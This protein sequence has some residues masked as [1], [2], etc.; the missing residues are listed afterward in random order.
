MQKD[1]VGLKA[2]TQSV[3]KTKTHRKNIEIEVKQRS[4]NIEIS[5]G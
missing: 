5:V 3:I 4:Q 2:K 1:K